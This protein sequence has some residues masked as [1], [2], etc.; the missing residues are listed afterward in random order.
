[1]E[2]AQR[3][4][5]VAF[6]GLR[7]RRRLAKGRSCAIRV[8]AAGRTDGPSQRRRVAPSRRVSSGR[9]ERLTHTVPARGP[10]A[11][12]HL[13][14]VVLVR[15]NLGRGPFFCFVRVVTYT[16]QMYAQSS[17]LAGR[18]AMVLSISPPHFFLSQHFVFFPARDRTAVT[19]Y[20]CTPTQTVALMLSWLESGQRT[21]EA[22]NESGSV[23]SEF[24]IVPQGG[25]YHDSMIED[26]TNTAQATVSVAAPSVAATAAAIAPAA[27]MKAAPM[28]TECVLGFASSVG[29]ADSTSTSTS[30]S[31][32]GYSDCCVEC[33]VC[34]TG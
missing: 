9:P 23:A 6:F 11:P 24:I 20:S 31:A 12:P 22:S 18:M 21:N 10:L 26:S 32:H 27:A 29:E 17:H 34:D 2:H 1:M 4:E 14:T 8:L 25:V 3:R 19:H 33:L 28:D 16:P 5:R 30:T 13:Q 15:R 7:P